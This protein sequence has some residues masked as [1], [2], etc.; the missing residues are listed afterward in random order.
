MKRSFL[1]LA[2][3]IGV[4]AAIWMYFLPYLAVSHIKSSLERGDADALSR[5]IDFPTLRSNLKDQ[6]NYQMA[7]QAITG[8][9][10]NPFAALG[11]LIGGSLVNNMID[12]YVTPYGLGQIITHKVQFPIDK[13][14][15]AGLPDKQT[16]DQ[17]FKAASCAYD[18]PSR[19]FVTL[20]GD[21]GEQTKLVLTRSGLSWRLTN[22]L[23]SPNAFSGTPPATPQSNK[24]DDERAWDER[25]AKSRAGIASTPAPTISSTPVPTPAPYD[26]SADR[27]DAVSEQTLDQTWAAV[28]NIYQRRA[29]LISN[30]VNT[31]SGVAPN[32]EKS[33]LVEVTNARDSVGRVQL[34][35]NKAP[36]DAAQLKQFQAA[37]GQLSNALLRLL[38][39]V[40]RY[41]DLKA[42]QNFVGLQAQ[43]EGIENRISVARGNFNTAAQSYNSTLP[44]GS[45]LRPFFSHAP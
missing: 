32:F 8:M 6:F 34:D 16:L 40:E 41:P 29:D 1:I 4:A 21:N 15:E 42:N 2:V 17:T 9:K 18:S 30:L 13:P 35:P 23:L 12:A 24:S 19:F 3:L 37:Q 43:L 7:S 22:I 39:V 27:I 5:D 45:G 28:C 20:R 38:V 14:A 11:A 26:Y 44:P 33:T 25:V 36:T 31:V 10:D